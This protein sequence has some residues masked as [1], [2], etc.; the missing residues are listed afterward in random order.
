MCHEG[1]N[2]GPVGKCRPSSLHQEQAIKEV[3]EVLGVGTKTLDPFVNP[4]HLFSFS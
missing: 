2:Q 4:S 1:I 3:N